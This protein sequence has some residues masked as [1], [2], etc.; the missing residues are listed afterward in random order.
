MG[1][2]REHFEAYWHGEIDPDAHHPGAPLFELEEIADGVAFVSS[3]ANS[4]VVRTADGLLIFD[5]G[6]FVLAGQVH[7][8]IRTWSHEPARRVVYTHGHVDHCFGVDLWEKHG[9]VEVIAHEALPARFRRYERTPGWNACINA[10]QFGGQLRWPLGYRYPDTV[11]R[12]RLD[13]DVGGERIELHHARGETDDATWAWLPARKV[14]AV[15]DLFIWA[16]PNAGNPQKVQRYP[17]DWARA[18]RTM[19]ALGAE[20]LAPGHGPPIYGHERVARAL[21]ETAA[22]LESLHDQ[23]VALM[24]EGAKLDDILATVRAPA[25]LLQRPYL[26]PTYDEP[27]FVVR[28]VYRLYGGWW[29]G[30]PATLKPAPEADLARELAALAGG[31]RN[32]AKRAEALLAG[33]EQRLAGHLAE[34]AA[35]AAPDD[36]EVFAIRARI[37]GARA[38]SERSLMAQG[39]FR[40][41]AQEKPRRRE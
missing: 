35:K 34:I 10:R 27:E 4:T 24:N 33:G 14:L 5:A 40:A 28:N 6:S 39:V 8:A 1:R 2:I 23:T 41:A 32:V 3:F 20:V 22:L 31:A 30:N 19:S 16:A 15:G 18:L 36:E 7:A 21:D 25:H 29:D 26:R 9:P 37:N 12:E 38:T 11:Y 13:L 17:L